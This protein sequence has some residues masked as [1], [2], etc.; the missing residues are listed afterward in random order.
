M[1]GREALKMGGR[2]E[3]PHLAFALPGRL[4]R[5]LDSVVR[6]PIAA[7]DHGRHHYAADDLDLGC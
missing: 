1:D 4:M 5:D 3:S 7:V 2:F 6:T